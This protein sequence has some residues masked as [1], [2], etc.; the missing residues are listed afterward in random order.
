ML[1]RRAFHTWKPTR[2]LRRSGLFRPFSSKSGVSD[3]ERYLFDLNGFL[4]LRGVFNAEEVKQANDSIDQHLE[5]V[6]E[7]Q[8]PALRNTRAKTPL[9]GDGVS[10]RKDLGGALGWPGS[11][12]QIFRRMLADQRLVPY[13]HEL[14]GVG[15]RLDHHPLIIIQDKGSEGFC[16]HGGTID[17]SSGKYNQ[18]LAYGC[19]NGQLT[20]SLLG[21]SLQLSDHNDGDGGFMIVRGSHKS[22]FRMPQGMIDGELYDEHIYQPV[23]KAGDV[24]IFSEGTV[25]GAKAWNADHQRRIALFRF[26]PC[27]MAYGRS[28]HEKWP[29]EFY[30]GMTAEQAAVLEPPYST[31][32]DRPIITEQGEVEV[33][34]RTDRKKKHD[35]QVFGTP[36]F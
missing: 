36:Y 25:H 26:A 29:A 31:R 3:D 11:Q 22:N 33:Q 1:V 20:T 2:A 18:H 14:L 12:S 30:E 16:M 17:C 27:T 28:Y 4:V 15:Y 34:S 10:G 5:E 24:V 7:R 21:V 8:E 35:R 23:T 13:Y 32:L 9:S 6:K 19:H